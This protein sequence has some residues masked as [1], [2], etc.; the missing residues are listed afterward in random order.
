MQSRPIQRIGRL[1]W[2][3]RNMGGSRRRSAQWVRSLLWV[4]K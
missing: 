1:V 2:M 4:C 3:V